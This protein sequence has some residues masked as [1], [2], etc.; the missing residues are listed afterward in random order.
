MKKTALALGFFDGMHLG[1][2]AILDVALDS[3]LT[4]SVF[5]FGG[6]E[7]PKFKKYNGRYLIYPYDKKMALLSEYGFEEIYAPNFSDVS[8]LTPVEFFEGVIYDKM[9]AGL[10]VC[11]EN[12]TFGKNGAGNAELLSRLCSERGIDVRIIPMLI[13][14]GEEISSSRIKR[15][16]LNGDVSAAA[17]LGTVAAYGGEVVH[18]ARLGHTLG[19]PTINMLFGEHRLIP[20]YGV[21]AARVSIGG[22]EYNGI[23]NIGVKPTIVGERAPLIETHLFDFTRETYGEYAE[24]TLLG[25]LRGERRFENVGELTLQMAQDIDRAVEYIDKIIQ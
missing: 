2:R 20:K 3:D 22:A 19:Y 11:G 24:V 14:D 12:F 6:G 23:S 25:F 18:G 13:S 5:T 17:A 10:V 8:D 15:L 7:M 21:Y 9:H 1:H 16:L 4:P